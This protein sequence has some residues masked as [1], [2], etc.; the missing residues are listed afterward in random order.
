[1]KPAVSK[2]VLASAV[3]LLVVALD[4]WLKFYIKTTFYLGEDVEILPFFHLRFVQ[5]PGMAFGMEL[6]SKLF[7]TLFRIVVTCVGFW[8]IVRKC[9]AP[10][11]PRG[12]VACV[13]LVVAGA[14]GNIVDCMLYGEIFTN[15][16]PPQV[17][18]LV[19]FGE[20]YG[21]L[22]YG[23]VVD[24]LYFPLFSFTWPDWLPWLGGKDFSFFDPVFNIADA[25]ITV[26][27]IAI[28]LFY[29]KY[30]LASDK[31]EAIEAEK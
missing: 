29:S 27:M 24:M 20:G 5:N 30:L 6:G 31:E 2:A 22:F 14:L 7:L 12:Y 4:Q 26:G 28:L 25:A 1:M 23:L 18:T 10:E 3:I 16:Y 19:P 9:K 17:A 11:V 8:Y 13:A 21:T 15:P